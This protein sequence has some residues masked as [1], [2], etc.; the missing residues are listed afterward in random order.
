MGLWSRRLFGIAEK[1]V[2]FDFRGFRGG[3]HPGIREHI[4]QIGLSF[5]TGYHHGHEEASVA[6]LVGRLETVD[7]AYRGF[8]YEGAAMA[9]FL[10]DR[11]TPWPRNRFDEFLDDLGDDHIYM[12][13]VGA[14]WALARLPFGFERGVQ[15]LDPLL[16]WLAYDGYG[17][18]QGYFHWQESMAGPQKRPSRVRGYGQRVF[19]Q[20]LGRSLWFVDGADVE[21]IP[22]TVAS[23]SPERQPDLWAGLGLS[24]TYAG[25]VP[26]EHL[27][28]L[29]EA[30]GEHRFL[31][32]QGAAFAAKARLRAGNLQPHNELA[33]EVLCGMNAADAA[34]VTDVALRG[35][36]ADTLEDPAYEIWRQR[37]QARLREA[38]RGQVQPSA[39]ADSARAAYA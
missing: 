9:L 10:M 13:I 29:R 21:R 32:A 8:A 18:H 35:L 27:E 1:E 24:S 23:F 17:F 39:E 22:Q 5:R 20:G 11:L 15:K 34:A 4:E 14:G 6:A 16:R 37:I 7:L 3:T 30:S 2:R 28:A 19:D 36:P 25:G 12:A 33:C 31:L 38:E 26:R